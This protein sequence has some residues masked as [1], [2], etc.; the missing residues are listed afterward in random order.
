MKAHHASRPYGSVRLVDGLDREDEGLPELEPGMVRC[1]CGSAVKR[2]ANSV[3][4]VNRHRTPLGRW[5]PQRRVLDESLHDL[6]A[7][8]PPVTVA[9]VPVRS[10]EE[11]DA[12]TREV[13]SDASRRA[14]V[15]RWSDPLPGD[16][17]DPLPDTTH[18]QYDRLRHRQAQWLRTR[19]ADPILPA[20]PGRSYA[21]PR[22]DGHC[23]GDECAAPVTGERLYCG[24]CMVVRNGSR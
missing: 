7:D 18:P 1:G 19:N 14:A 16:P 24:P 3:V 23:H 2:R 21:R 15:T 8:L 13:R 12:R 20:V 9:G 10:R 11:F 17:W 4:Y 5:C 6:V 22:P